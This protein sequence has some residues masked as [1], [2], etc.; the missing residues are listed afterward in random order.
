MTIAGYKIHNAQLNHWD[1]LLREWIQ[2]FERLYDFT[3]TTLGWN[4]QEDSNKG[5]FA[6]AVWRLGW[7]AFPEIKSKRTLLGGYGEVDFYL[8]C[9]PLGISEYV[10]C[11][12]NKIW[13]V[14]QVVSQATDCLSRAERHASTIID[15]SVPSRVGVAFC[16]MLFAKTQKDAIPSLVEQ[17]MAAVCRDMECDAIGWCFPQSVRAYEEESGVFNPG[18]ILLARVAKQGDLESELV[19]PGQ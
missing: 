4:A 15:P 2:C 13:A 17:C 10:E 9:P 7:V 8:A 6:G 5:Q 11:K 19:L 1:L 3:R 16:N 18:V 14:S 12:G